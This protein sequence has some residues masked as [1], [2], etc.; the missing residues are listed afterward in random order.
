ML[1]NAYDT[2]VGQPF[3][4]ADS[5]S[6]TLK[7]L[8]LTNGLPKEKEGQDLYL[9]GHG[10]NNI[11][12]FSFPI[13]LVG[14]DRKPITVIDI[15]PYTNKLGKIVNQPEYTFITLAGMLQ[16]NINVGEL[17]LLKS[18]RIL[19]TRV[20]AKSLAQKF[21]SKAGLDGYE[22][23]LL[24]LIFAN[25]HTMQ[26][27]SGSGDYQF[28]STNVL[29]TALGL[30]RSVTA[31]IIEDMG[32]ITTIRE[33]I[34]YIS[35]KPELYKLNS[36]NLKEFITVGSTI[37][38]S[39]VGKQIVGAA[40]EHPCLFSSMVYTTIM[41]RMFNKT[42]VGLQLDPKYNGE[43]VESFAKNITTSIK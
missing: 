25:F 40:L 33:L 2:T 34:T 29:N 30:D 6:D 14:H 16:Q 42:G 5:I 26:Y 1:L 39:S 43:L 4:I 8:V 24:Q 12:E 10:N 35:T 11:K 9:V 7:T 17:T 32:F 38:F 21:E 15:R 20:Y 31:S 19:A 3:K 13:S 18:G 22:T 27:E 36:L 37:W 28:V 23:I 41:N